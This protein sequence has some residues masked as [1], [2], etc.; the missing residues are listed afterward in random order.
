MSNCLSVYVTYCNI[1]NTTNDK[2][3]NNNGSIYIY[4]YMCDD[5]DD[6]DDENVRWPYR[7]DLHRDRLSDRSEALLMATPGHGPA[8]LPWQI[9]I[10]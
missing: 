6:D 8:A 3:N 4:I 10:L 9:E 1:S 5:D 7:L 2:T